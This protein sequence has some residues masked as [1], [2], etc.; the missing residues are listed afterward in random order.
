[1]RIKQEQEAK[2]EALRIQQEQEIEA[3]RILAEQ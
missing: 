3:E 2:A 1:M